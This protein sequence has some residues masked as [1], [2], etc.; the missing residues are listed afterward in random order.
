MPLKRSL[1]ALS[2]GVGVHLLRRDRL[3]PPRWLHSVGTSDYAKTG[4]E[5]FRYFLDFAGLKPA[6][7]VLDVG[8][9]T[10][11]M[12]RPLTKY[13]TG[14]Y[15][16]IDI[17]RPAIEWCTKIYARRFPNFHFHFA[18]IY[19]GQFN[20]AG[21]YS[22]SEYR[23]RFA[24]SAFDLVLLTSVLTHMLLPDIENYLAE[25]SRVLKPGASCFATFFL[26]T[27]ESASLMER[28]LSSLD[29]KQT[30]HNY[31]IKSEESPELAVALDQETICTLFEKNNLNIVRPIRYGSW[32]GRKNGLSYQDIII[33]TRAQ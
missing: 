8:S 33:A 22:A 31:W 30:L 18:D 17:V 29:F 27:P 16:G 14:R 2:Y 6:H 23:F 3:L 19:N 11:R 24:D 21:K 26:I 32:C 10:G 12:A 4:E 5:F 15:D 7:A 1:T 25:T 9:G 28:G 13:L 20:P